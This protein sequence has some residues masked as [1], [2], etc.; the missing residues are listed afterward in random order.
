MKEN[1]Q[2]TSVYGVKQFVGLSVSQKINAT[3]RMGMS[4][5]FMKQLVMLVV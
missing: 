2:Y 1:N 5:S 3:N 4:L